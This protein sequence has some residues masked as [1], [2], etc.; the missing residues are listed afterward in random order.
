VAGR[1]RCAHGRAQ[2]K[3]TA[4]GNHK[5]AAELGSGRGLGGDNGGQSIHAGGG[6]GLEVVGLALSECGVDGGH[7]DIKDCDF[8]F[9]RM[10]G[11][12]RIFHGLAISP[13]KKNE[14]YAHI[15]YNNYIMEYSSAFRQLMRKLHDLKKPR[16]HKFKYTENKVRLPF[17]IQHYLRPVWDESDA[18]SGETL[19]SSDSDSIYEDEDSLYSEESESSYESSIYDDDTEDS[20]I[21][22]RKKFTYKP[23]GI[24]LPYPF[25][26]YVRY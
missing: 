23:N 17:K 8:I 21:V 15:H 9:K 25:N 4:G 3:A 10:F 20:L 1:D 22:R 26:P 11:E 12:K 2:G 7:F 6:I 24:K 18:G 19:S 13:T 5:H 16:I 14:Q